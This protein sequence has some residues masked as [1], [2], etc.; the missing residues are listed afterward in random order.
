V[1]LNALGGRRLSRYERTGQIDDLNEAIELMQDLEE[2]IQISRRAV[3]A[4]P[5]PDLWTVSST[6]GAAL[7]RRYER[8]LQMED[9]TEAIRM[10][11]QAVQATPHGRV[12]TSAVLSSNL[13][14]M[15]R[16]RY[17]RTGEINDLE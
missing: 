16:V 7:G 6:L 2:A 15:L 4:T 9:I 12:A 17:E 10:L 3:Q 13:A 11:C 5:D 1:S 8:T 14:I